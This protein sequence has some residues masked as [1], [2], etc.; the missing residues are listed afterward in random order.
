MDYN[1]KSDEFKL[2][3]STA[4]EVKDTRRDIMEQLALTKAAIKA[5]ETIFDDSYNAQDYED[6]RN[7]LSNISEHSLS[8]KALAES[9]SVRLHGMRSANPNAY[10]FYLSTSN[11]YCEKHSCPFTKPWGDW[12]CE[13]CYSDAMEDKTVTMGHCVACKGTRDLVD[14]KYCRPHYELYSDMVNT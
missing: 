6:C 13:R 4:I 14:G 5:F 2:G 12:M 3:H 8:A 7:L 10:Q 11:G 9:V 1:L